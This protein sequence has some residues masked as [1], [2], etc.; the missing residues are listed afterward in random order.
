MQSV[1]DNDNG[2]DK[3]HVGLSRDYYML[4]YFKS[5][6]HENDGWSTCRTTL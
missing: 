1:N 6:K 5:L 3:L 4:G 2:N